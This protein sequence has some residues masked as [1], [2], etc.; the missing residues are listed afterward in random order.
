[1][2]K[3]TSKKRLKSL[4]R[5]DPG[6]W[7]RKA[8]A[9]RTKDELIDALVKTAR[10]DRAVVRRLS[11]HLKLQMPP[12]ELLAATRQAI[13]DATAFDERDINHNFSYDYEAYSAVQRNLQ[14]LI[15]LGQLRP[16]MEL[17]LELMDQGSYQV[18]MSDEGLMT[19][20]IEP[21]LRVVLKALR[22]CDLPAR[23]VIAWCT[24][25]L[26]RDRTQFLCDQELGALREQFETR[27][28]A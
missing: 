22:T 14:R 26:E 19:E 2:S 7:L 4:K 25:M 1:M 6:P 27:P 15:E 10:D 28:S 21:C 9:Q 20:D 18:Q 8:L 3:R 5:T 12:K 17:S 13:A 11:S 24:A 23:E 16:V